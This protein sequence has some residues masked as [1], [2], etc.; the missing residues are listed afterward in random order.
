[1]RGPGLCRGAG[2]CVGVGGGWGGGCTHAC[3][4]THSH[5][6]RRCFAAQDWE[7]ACEKLTEGLAVDPSSA[8]AWFM[9]GCAAMNLGKVCV[10]WEG[11]GGCTR[12]HTRTHTHTHARTHTHAHTR[13]HSYT[14]VHAHTHTHTHAH[15]RTHTHTLI[16]THAHTQDATA[17]S[18]LTSA[19]QREPDNGKAWANLGAVFGRAA[20]YKEALA[21]TRLAVKHSSEWAM[22]LWGG[23]VGVHACVLT[24]ARTHAHTHTRTAKSW[25]MHENYILF[26][27]RANDVPEVS[28]RPCTHTSACLHPTPPRACARACVRVRL[29]LRV[30][31]VCV[32]QVCTHTHTHTHAHTHT[33]SGD[34]RVPRNS[35]SARATVAHRHPPVPHR[36][37]R[38]PRGCVSP[39][40]ARAQHPRRRAAP[41]RTIPYSNVWTLCYVM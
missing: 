27:L 12:A 20:R 13:T 18:A 6:P 21:A 24:H 14:L 31:A 36:A 38:A 34:H 26:A 4:H 15:T 2:E 8:G 5:T 1:M 28:A 10:G 39:P 29:W 33:H 41:Q 19:L 7:G 37:V 3:T 32:R 22:V 9:L 11:G 17:L 16:R 23:G 35:G 25:K 30:R 40:G